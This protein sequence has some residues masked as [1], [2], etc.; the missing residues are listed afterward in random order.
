MLKALRHLT[1]LDA[2]KR[3]RDWYAANLDRLDRATS[4]SLHLNLGLGPGPL[5]VAQK[6]L[7]AAMAE[8]LPAG[9]W[10]DVGCG[11]GGP[12]LQWLDA[13]PA[14]RVT[15]LELVPEILDRARIHIPRL[16]GRLRLVGGDAD[17]MP[18]DPEFDAVIALDSVWH[19]RDRVQ[20]TQQAWRALKPGGVLRLT[21]LACRP[22]HLR[23]YDAA[24][25]AAARKGLGAHA[26]STAQRWTATLQA[27]GF[28]AVT[29]TDQSAERVDLLED[30]SHAVG[31][32]LGRGLGYLHQR[33]AGGPLAF[34]LVEA[35]KEA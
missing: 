24:V 15:G 29:V 26:L 34:L 1:R 31:G 20:F 13:D 14:L 5:P 2:T 3:T 11:L 19:V 9:H 28:E 18:F 21:D 22:E 27:N 7:A 4:G 10:L 25:V 6:A 33:R 17:Q 23:L 12:A 8:G 30:W 32:A 35:R 16:D